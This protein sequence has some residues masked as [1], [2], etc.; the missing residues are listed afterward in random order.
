MT[1]GKGD[2]CYTMPFSDSS[3]PGSKGDRY[4]RVA[5]GLR[6]IGISLV[7]ERPLRGFFKHR[8]NVYR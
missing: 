2:H 5:H 6:G 7:Q 4:T 8:R 3:F 1:S